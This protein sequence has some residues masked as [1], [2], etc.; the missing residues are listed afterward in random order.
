[1]FFIFNF[2]VSTYLTGPTVKTNTQMS[3]SSYLNMYRK[4]SNSKLTE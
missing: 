3:E 4:D 1:M 2:T